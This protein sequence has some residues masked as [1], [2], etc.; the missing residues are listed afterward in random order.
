MLTTVDNY[1]KVINVIVLISQGHTLTSACD[2]QRI[3]FDV[4]RREVNKVP[5]LSA[6]FVDAEQRSYDVM[7]DA[8]L[9]PF[10][11]R[12]ANTYGE[13]DPK[14]AK[15][16]SDNIKWYLARKRPYQYGDKSII[17]HQFT[18]DKTIVEALQRGKDNVMK[19]LVEDATYSVVEDTVPTLPP[20][21]K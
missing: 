9:D 1:T 18:A 12:Q 11:V 3:S 17:E 20:E 15:I 16:M 19:A 14:R 4:F 8:L 10:G 7:A 13:Q 5:E 21:L 2:E 6:L